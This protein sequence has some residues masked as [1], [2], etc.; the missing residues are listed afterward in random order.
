VTLE[1]TT[2]ILLIALPV[3]F[4]LCFFLLGRT[5][6]Y[7]DVLRQPTA[8]ILRRFRAGGTALRLTWHGFALT[9]VALAP[10]AVL[11]GQVFGGEDLAVVPVATAFGVLAAA[12]QVLGLIRWPYL[13]PYLARID[14]DPSASPATREA[15]AVVFQAVHRTLGMAIGEHLGYLFTGLWTVLVGVAMTESAA[16]GAW[17]GWPGVALGLALV[18]GAAEFAG[19]F[20]DSGWGLAGKLVPIAYGLW[21]LWLVAAGATLLIG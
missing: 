19:P 15:V 13:V 3:A 17:L 5:F 21:S 4:N 11:M 18:V 7:P 16:F 14:A 10:V 20:E 9:A 6:G 1:R 8:E 2:G 12:V